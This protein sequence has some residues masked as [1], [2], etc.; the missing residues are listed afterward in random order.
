MRVITGSARGHKLAA[1][2][3]LNTRPTTDMTKEAM[4]SIV[5]FLVE[6]IYEEKWG[7]H[8]YIQDPMI[9]N[10]GLVQAS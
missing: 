4:F 10:A 8:I 9:K 6:G 3:G 5:Q 2:E 7:E 1:P